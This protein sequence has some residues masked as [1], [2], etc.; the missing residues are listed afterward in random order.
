MRMKSLWR[1]LCG[2]MR[3]N[4]SL[5]EKWIVIIV[6]TRKFTRSC[7][8]G[9]QPIGGECLVWTVSY[10]FNRTLL[11]WRYCYRW[12]VCGN[13]T[14]IHFTRY[15]C[16]LW[17]Q[18]GLLPTR[19]GT[20]TLPPRRAGFPAWESGRTLDR[21]KRYIWIPTTFTRFNTS[22][23]L[24]LG[25]LEGCRVSQETSYTGGSLCRN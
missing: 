7:W 11:H 10:R 14:L 1:R 23:L 24:P 22:G 6:F 4:I 8:Q 12:S 13:A 20:P 15:T 2:L 18:W 3:P 16:T 19:Q 5:M 25:N 21:M 17:Q 9:G